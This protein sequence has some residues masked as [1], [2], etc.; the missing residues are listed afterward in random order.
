MMNLR[1]MLWLLP[2]VLF[3]LYAPALAGHDGT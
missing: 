2:G 1:K 3:S